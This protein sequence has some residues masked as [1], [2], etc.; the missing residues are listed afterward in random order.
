MFPNPLV[1][2]KLN[3]FGPFIPFTDST[4]HDYYHLYRLPISFTYPSRRAHHF[5]LPHARTRR[6]HT[7]EP[8]TEG[9]GPTK[10]RAKTSKDKRVRRWAAS[11]RLQTGPMALAS[12]SLVCVC[13]CVC[14]SVRVSLSKVAYPYCASALLDA[15]APF[16]LG[17]RHA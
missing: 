2:Q 14:V 3:L 1:F 12:P 5:P 13:V 6:Q 10:W 7:Q 11:N 16:C 9:R 8:R 17:V 15:G 4:R